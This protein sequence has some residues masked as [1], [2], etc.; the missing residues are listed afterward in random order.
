MKRLLLI[1]LPL[2]LIVGCSKS[3]E[4]STL[5]TKDGVMFSPDSDKPYTG[6]VFINYSTGEKL[7]QGT[8]KD[9][10]LINYSYLNEDGSVKE[11]IN[12]E[13]T[14]IDRDGVFYTKDTNKLYSG[15]VFSLN[16]KGL[17]KRE[18]ILQDGEMTTYTD[19]EWYENGQKEYEQTHKNGIFDG[20]F[21]L[22]YENGQK[23]VQKTFKDGKLDGLTT[24]WYENGQ[25]EY[26]QTHK[27]GIF[28]GPFTLWY[29]NGQKAKEGN[30]KDGKEDGLF[31]EWFENGQKKVEET[32]KNGRLD[33]STLSAERLMEISQFELDQNNAEYAIY[34]LDELINNYPEDRLASS[35]QYKIASI[36]KNWRNDPAN[37]IKSLKKTVNNYPNSLHT[38]QAKKE[39]ASFQDWIINNAETLRKRKLTF[40][41]INNL[42]Y[43]VEN[44]PQHELASKAQ[45]IVGDIYMNDLR[46]F[47]KALSEYRVVLSNYDGS[48]EEPLAEFMIG[49]IYANVLKD[50]KEANKIYQNFLKR[51]PNHELAP[52]VKF[53]LDFIGK[54]INEIPA[55]K[56][57]S[58]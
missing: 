31:T 25:K 1:V 22:W 8:Y 13:T 38:K 37:F 54:N 9:G 23:N 3:I 42:I 56:H 26:E 51:F 45:Y 58:S 57:I 5:I 2:L 15:P 24:G 18:S 55:L 34:A 10:L 36:Y 19:F 12:Y 39:I 46:D 14:L 49:Y 30:L 27:N 41:S 43:L 44:F 32:Y 48:K 29:E 7:Y 40:E 6:E 21:T 35:A 16:D 4:D 53:E 50:F 47:E 52:S 33:L 11:P 28:D 17:N 20:P